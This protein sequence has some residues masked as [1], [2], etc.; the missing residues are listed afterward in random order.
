M[1][2]DQAKKP[3]DFPPF[4]V[5][6]FDL[7]DLIAHRFHIDATL[8][9][10][11]QRILNV[12]IL[13]SNSA[14]EHRVPDDLLPKAW[15]ERLRFNRYPATYW[16]KLRGDPATGTVAGKHGGGDEPERVP[17]GI[18][19]PSAEQ[20]FEEFGQHKLRPQVAE[21]ASPQSSPGSPQEADHRTE[22]ADAQVG[23]P[24][25]VFSKERLSAWF[26]LRIDARQKDV[27]APTEEQ[28]L[29]AAQEYFDRVPRDVFRDVRRHKV[30]IAWQKRGRR[31]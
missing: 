26:V 25:A 14:I 17:V 5:R 11:V 6:W 4:W 12:E 22:A 27:P 2:D 28:D 30:P 23:A 18:Y 10:Q 15:L 7:P 1:T 19:L 3:T 24:K 29:L 13:R 16:S 8:L 9:D 20:W 21:A 31:T